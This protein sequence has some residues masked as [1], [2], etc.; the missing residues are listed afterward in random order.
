MEEALTYTCHVHFE[1]VAKGRKR[2]ITGER[3]EG[4]EPVKPGNVPRISKLMALAIRFEEKLAKGEVRDM[5][6][7]AMLGHV[8]RARVTQ[9]MNLR[10]LAPD[11][12]EALLSLSRTLKGRD[13][14]QYR[15]VLPIT[16]EPEW[17]KQRRM[18]KNLSMGIA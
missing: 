18:W 14:I 6:H 3:P 8:T 13:P 17:N 5:A 7:L 2:L 1:R 16:L 11:I 12:Q 9:I 15:H 4:Q 10:L